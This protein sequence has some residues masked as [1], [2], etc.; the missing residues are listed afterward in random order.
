LHK[1]HE[2]L[3]FETVKVTKDRFSH[4]A[5]TVGGR[6]TKKKQLERRFWWKRKRYVLL[7]L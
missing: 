5:R 7:H 2:L 6:E 1:H 4:N 3:P